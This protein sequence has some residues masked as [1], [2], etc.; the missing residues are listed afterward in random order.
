MSPKCIMTMVAFM[1][2]TGILIGALCILGGC[3]RKQHTEEMPPSASPVIKASALIP[4]ETTPPERMDPPRDEV[5]E[6]SGQP[7][8]VISV[9]REQDHEIVRALKGSG[10]HYKVGKPY[11]I[12][13]VWYFPREDWSYDE[14]GHESWYGEDFHGKKT[15]NGEVFDM[16]KIS[17]AHRTLPLPCLVRVTNMANG[18]STII[19][20][21]DRGPFVNNRILDLSRAAARLLRIS[22]YGSAT[23]RVQVLSKESQMLREEM[24]AKQNKKLMKSGKRVSV[25]QAEEERVDNEQRAKVR[26]FFS[27]LLEPDAESVARK[28][29]PKGVYV[30]QAASFSDLDDAQRLAYRIRSEMHYDATV[31]RITTKVGQ[32]VYH[33]HVV[34]LPS[35]A[36]ARTA[37]RELR[38]RYKI[39]D[40]YVV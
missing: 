38:S 20:V 17:A 3:G 35:Q 26:G 40:A 23:V 18:M 31:K 21:N 2:Q 34:H 33:V 4:F 19:R 24:L 27:K 11:K 5:A 29:D 6:L 8:Q 13:G 9:E 14:I 39:K 1:I 25:Q 28:K 7:S 37:V 30:V 36:Q 32:T 12:D 15:A 16:D 22:K 10:G